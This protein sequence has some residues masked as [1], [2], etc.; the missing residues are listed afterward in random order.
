MQLYL[1]LKAHDIRVGG[2]GI[3][4][5]NAGNAVRGQYQALL[6]KAN[7]LTSSIDA[8]ISTTES[9]LNANAEIVD[10]RIYFEGNSKK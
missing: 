2:N 5:S 1:Q 6:K 10:S 9:S 7:E 8:I 4:Y 3:T